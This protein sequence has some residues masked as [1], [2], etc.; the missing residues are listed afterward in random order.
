[1]RLVLAGF[2]W[3]FGFGM[4]GVERREGFWLCGRFGIGDLWWLRLG[5]GRREGV[6]GVWCGVVW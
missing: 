1:M 5:R 4:G 3:G 6:G 2:W